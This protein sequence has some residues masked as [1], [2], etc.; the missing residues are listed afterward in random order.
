[1]HIVRFISFIVYSAVIMLCA[2]V[3]AFADKAAD[4]ASY[5]AIR[6]AAA[7]GE[8]AAAE[9][10]CAE[11]LKKYPG[12]NLVPDVRMVMADCQADPEEAL[13]QY[14]VIRDKYR[15]YPRRARAQLRICEIHFFLSQWQALYDESGRGISLDAAEAVQFRYFR[16]LAAVQLGNIEEAEK[17]CRSITGDGHSHAARVLLAYITRQKSGNSREYIYALREAAM[18][19][20]ENAVHPSVLYL[21]GKFYESQG[22]WDR[23][24][25]AYSDVIGRYPGSPEAGFSYR[26]AEALKDKNPKRR[27]YLPDERTI[28]QTDQLDLQPEIDADEESGA[29]DAWHYSLSIGPF[30]S[31]ANARGIK[32]TV[33]EFGTVKMARTR[34]GYMI[35][36]GSFAESDEALKTRIRLA[37]EYGINAHIVRVSRDETRQYIHGE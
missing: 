19:G 15:F 13:K 34:E 7:D 2:A 6:T 29:A 3:P 35:Y 18:G 20:P 4:L 14:A 37:E 25:S 23:A 26:R 24:Y 36:L 12:S 17:Q 10:L 5:D 31:A 11:F 27:Q 1:M 30:G 22:D 28:R 16:A 9:K 32:K 33:E 8:T 21:L